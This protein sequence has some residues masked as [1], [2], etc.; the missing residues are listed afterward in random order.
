MTL[1]RRA[2]SE[3]ARWTPAHE[4]F[5]TICALGEAPLAQIA[6]VPEAVTPVTRTFSPFQISLGAA[7]GAP[8]ATQPRTVH[9]NLEGDIQQLIELH[10]R[11]EGA[12]APIGLNRQV[13]PLGCHIQLGRLR[14][15]SES[16]RSD[17]GRAIRMAQLGELGTW[18]V[19]KIELLRSEVGPAGPTTVDVHSFPLG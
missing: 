19:E 3:A 15:E 18:T 16:A 17:L 6:R 9:I 1:R 8:S 10:K 2:G 5:I 14:V 13:V 11:I 4:L 12:I 7:G